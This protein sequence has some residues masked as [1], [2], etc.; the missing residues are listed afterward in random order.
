[1]DE[2]LEKEEKNIQ[3]FLNSKRYEHCVNVKIIFLF[4][5][6][7]E[8]LYYDKRPLQKRFTK[9]LYKHR[10]NAWL[11]VIVRGGL[12]TN[13]WSVHCTPHTSHMECVSCNSVG[14]IIGSSSGDYE[15]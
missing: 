7:N 12:K 5:S 11:K 14:K 1:M 6:D 4:Y 13:Y 2:F 3:E 10:S 9:A 8:L 15:S